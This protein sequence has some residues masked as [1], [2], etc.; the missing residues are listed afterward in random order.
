MVDSEVELLRAA[1]HEVELFERHNDSLSELGRIHLAAR[2][3][4]SA[5]ARAEVEETARRFDPD[6]AHVHNTFPSLSPS[7]YGALYR[8]AIPIVQTMHN[9]RWLCPQAMF[10]REGHVCE[11]CLGRLPWPGVMHGCYRS[12]RAQTVVLSGMLSLHNW[13]GTLDRCVDRVI[14]LS[15][16]G[17]QKFVA[18]GL[19]AERVVVKPNFV[20]GSE[21][22]VGS[23]KAGFLFVGRLSEEKGIAVLADAARQLPDAQITVVGEGTKRSLV[24]GIPNVRCMGGLGQQAVMAEMAG[25]S[26][27]LVPSICYE[28]FPRTIAEAYSVGLPVIASR[29]GALAEIVSDGRTGL[30]FEAGNGTDLACVMRTAMKDRAAQARMGAEARSDYD[31]KYSPAVNL[32]RL[33]S[34]YR[35]AIS[36]RRS[37]R[38]Q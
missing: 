12:S 14:A 16:F 25:A 21:S 17:R 35:E 31:R 10:L 30:H 2:T 11:S 33:I 18:G 24:E 38:V 5:A 6:V 19:P 7:I 1:G 15:E 9:F 23:E 4:W 27:L 34:I 22:V 37:K 26:W 20:R 28:G 32:D 29:I 36:S 8:R 13:L 3:I